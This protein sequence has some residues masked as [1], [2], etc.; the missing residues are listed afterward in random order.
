MT[1][2]MEFTF[3]LLPDNPAWN[4]MFGIAQPPT[5]ERALLIRTTKSCPLLTGKRGTSTRA[6][7]ARRLRVARLERR[8]AR[9]G[10]R[11]V[12]LMDVQHYFPRVLIEEAV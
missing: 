3:T 2:P 6:E 4:A 5:T 1:V 9:R 12:R 8:A 11:P 7:H 10:N